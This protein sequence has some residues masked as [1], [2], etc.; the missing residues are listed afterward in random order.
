MKLEITR[1]RRITTLTIKI[2]F[3]IFSLHELIFIISN[4][5]IDQL[6]MF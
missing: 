6:R 2:N 3:F 4:Q 1:L 5:L